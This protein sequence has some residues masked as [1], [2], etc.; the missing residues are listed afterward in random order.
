MLGCSPVRYLTAWRMQVAEQWLR[1]EKYTLAA[2]AERLGY[3]SEPAFSRAF[4]RHR[5]ISPGA[6]ATD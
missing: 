1:E 5:G 6:A 2:V 4:K 3:E